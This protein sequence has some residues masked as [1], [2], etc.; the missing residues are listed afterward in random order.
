MPPYS[1]L[2]CQR[3]LPLNIWM[4]KSYST[5]IEL[6]ESMPVGVA[7]PHWFFN[8]LIRL[9]HGS[10]TCWR[11]TRMSKERFLP[12]E[13]SCIEPVLQAK[14]RSAEH[15]LGLLWFAFRNTPRQ[16]SAIRLM[17][18]PVAAAG[19]TDQNTSAFKPVVRRTTC[20][21]WDSVLSGRWSQP[22]RQIGRVAE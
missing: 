17:G 7:K 2:I 3:R 4:V 16:C 22:G 20:A 5:I 19:G 8:G 15:R 14:A 11:R 1:V 6:A 13:T 12:T 21:M 9:F 10:G 18:R